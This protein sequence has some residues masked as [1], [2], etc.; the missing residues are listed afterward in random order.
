MRKRKGR[1]REF[2][3]RKSKERDFGESN[4]KE[5][6]LQERETGKKWNFQNIQDQRRN[7]K[8]NV[9]SCKITSDSTRQSFKK[10]HPDRII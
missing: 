4:R 1:E 7:F 6:E 9:F 3:E 2:R 10:D 8:F 5:R